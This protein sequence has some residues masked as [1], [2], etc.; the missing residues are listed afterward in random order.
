MLLNHLFYTLKPMIPRRVQ[1]AL[2]RQLA[3]HKRRKYAHIW[4]IDPNSATPPQGWPG[5]P[6]CKR[7]AFTLCHD[8]D[9][10][11]GYDN[12][13]RLA[14]LEESMG[15]RSLFSFVPEGYGEISLNLL[16]DLR[17][18]GFDVAVHGLNHDGKLFRSRR[19]FLLQA[20]KINEYLEKWGTKGF[21]SPSM[22]HN[23]E[24][25]GAMNIEYSISTFDTDPF[26]PQPDGVGTIFPFLVPRK[27]VQGSEF[28]V[29]DSSRRQEPSTQNLGPSTQHQEPSTQNLGPSTQHPEP[30]FFVE[31][32]YTLPQD[33]TLFI[34]LQEETIDIWKKKIDWIAKRGGMALVNT[35]P[36][37]MQLGHDGRSDLSYPT[38]LYI[39]FLE[40]VHQRYGGQYFQALPVNIAAFGLGSWFSANVSSCS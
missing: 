4:P 26:E 22:H 27:R 37:Y 7:F 28:R 18:R 19:D 2:R 11:R 24:W 6:D 34:I 40:Y 21:T 35:H 13:L 31:L 12:V 16:D 8:V 17:N 39:D 38:K 29:Q 20:Q 33:S 30:S 1:I 32:P 25:M 36:D 15:F 5:W 14:D 9:T 23:L 10:R 3:A